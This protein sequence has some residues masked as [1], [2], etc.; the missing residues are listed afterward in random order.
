M[1]QKF[2][3]PKGYK[4]KYKGSAQSVCSECNRYTTV[5]WHHMI[6]GKNRRKYSDFFML[7]ALLCPECHAKLHSDAKMDLE[8]KQRAQQRFNENYPDLDFVDIFGRNYL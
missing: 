2:K 8:Y 5:Q 1:K 6:H 7:V 4:I 3:L